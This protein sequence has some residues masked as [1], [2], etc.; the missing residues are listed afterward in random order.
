MFY[1][2]QFSGKK[3]HKQSIIRKRRHACMHENHLILLWSID[4]VSKIVNLYSHRLQFILSALSS[5]NRHK[6]KQFHFCLSFKELLFVFVEKLK[7]INYPSGSVLSCVC[8]NI[9]TRSQYLKFNV[10]GSFYR[11]I[12]AAAAAAASLH[13]KRFSWKM[14]HF[15]F[16]YQEL[17]Y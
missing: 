5:F 3:I 11:W 15:R 10:V 7:R 16:E 9:Q 17:A 4:A 14:A 8:Y 12:D 2:F 13:L 1:E 6:E